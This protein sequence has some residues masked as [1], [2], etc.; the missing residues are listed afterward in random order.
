VDVGFG[1]EDGE[2]VV[3]KV[4]VEV[5]KED[6]CEDGDKVDATVVA[7][8]EGDNVVND[9]TGKLDI[10]KVGLKIGEEVGAEVLDTVGV[11]V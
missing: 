1:V 2:E 7:R 10:G 6:D 3:F 5:E 9:E 4:G 8:N 11:N